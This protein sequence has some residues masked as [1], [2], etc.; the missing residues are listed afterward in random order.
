M[1]DENA[2]KKVR[3]ASGEQSNSEWEDQKALVTPTGESAPNP[4]EKEMTQVV[5]PAPRVAELKETDTHTY[6]RE[7]GDVVLWESTTAMAAR[8]GHTM[9]QLSLGH[10]HT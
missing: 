3:E 10:S 4:V 2:T 7:Q 9:G 6:G 1:M 8:T 5:R